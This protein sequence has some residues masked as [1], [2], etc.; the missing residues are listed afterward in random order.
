MATT[1]SHTPEDCWIADDTTAV[2]SN[3]NGEVEYADRNKYC[4]YD[5]CI[6]EG[7]LNFVF[8]LRKSYFVD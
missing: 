4:N 3:E 5:D 8:K 2:L 6:E 7:E 1:V